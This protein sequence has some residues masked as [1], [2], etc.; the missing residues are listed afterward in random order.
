MRGLLITGLML[1]AG[2]AAAANFGVSV[3]E[4]VAGVVGRAELGL[5]DRGCRPEFCAVSDRSE[6]RWLYIQRD[7]RNVV[8]QILFEV[9]ASAWSES[10]A[11]L[12]VVQSGLL[13]PHLNRIADTDITRTAKTLPGVGVS[14]RG[15]AI[16]CSA[17]VRKIKPET[18]LGACRPS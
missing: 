14:V 6:K 18:V 2:Q 3:E 16:I 11:I 9:P 4:F 12:D 1:V 8:T 10:A 17:L 13:I 5:R 7:R 15:R